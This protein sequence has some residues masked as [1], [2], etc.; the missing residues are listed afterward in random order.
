MRLVHHRQDETSRNGSAP[1]DGDLAA[2]PNYL[3]VAA[4]LHAATSTGP[5]AL[6][7]LQ[8][9]SVHRGIITRRFFAV[10]NGPQGRASIRLLEGVFGVMGGF[11]L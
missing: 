11:G 8:N 9:I 2:T 7:N 1:T 5:P 4:V 6:S 10:A 3:T